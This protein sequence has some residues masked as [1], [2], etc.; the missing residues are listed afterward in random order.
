[1]EEQ[2]TI[3]VDLCVKT[4]YMCQAFATGLS[5]HVWAIDPCAA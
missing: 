2:Q 3:T 4:F 1:M 5:L